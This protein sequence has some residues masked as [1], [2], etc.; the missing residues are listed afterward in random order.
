M[1]MAWFITG[2]LEA[3]KVRNFITFIFCRS[4][5]NAQKVHRRSIWSMSKS[6]MRW[7]KMFA[8][9]SKWKAEKF[10]R[11][12]ILPQMWRGLHGS[13]TQNSRIICLDSYKPWRLLFWRHFSLNFPDELWEYDGVTA[14]GLF[15]WAQD[16]RFQ[17]CRTKRFEVFQSLKD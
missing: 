7:P 15:V 3:L 10:S 5:Q 1:C 17:Y 2:I 14:D 6:S 11:Q 4:C 8:C 13:E 12:N 16:F 9:G